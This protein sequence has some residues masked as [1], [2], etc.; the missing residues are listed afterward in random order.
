MDY[1]KSNDSEQRS[2]D[3]TTKDKSTS[4]ISKLPVITLGAFFAGLTLGKLTNFRIVDS[5]VIAAVLGESMGLCFIP[6]VLVWLYHKTGSPGYYW[7]A[8]AFFGFLF[9]GF[10]AKAINP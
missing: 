9:L 2:N 7:G 6:A 3:S 1:D 8:F 5:N 10:I 4:D